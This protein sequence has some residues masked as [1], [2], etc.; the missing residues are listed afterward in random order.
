M[1]QQQQ[2]D[3]DIDKSVEQISPTLQFFPFLGTRAAAYL[4]KRSDEQ[5][6]HDQGHEDAEDHGQGLQPGQGTAHGAAGEQPHQVGLAEIDAVAQHQ[7]GGDDREVAPDRK[8][9]SPQV[10]PLLQAADEHHHHEE[11]G[12]QG[13]AAEGVQ[14]PGAEEVGRVGEIKDAEHQTETGADC[15]KS[16][17]TVLYGFSQQQREQGRRDQ[18]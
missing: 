2:N 16:A 7:D 6:Q 5:R 3:V 8:Q 4:L 15:V 11:G 18:R 1:G 10:R 17:G 12:A 14:H 13:A 9:L